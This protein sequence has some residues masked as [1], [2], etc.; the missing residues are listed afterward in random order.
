MTMSC[1]KNKRSPILRNRKYM[2]KLGKKGVRWL[3]VRAEWL[4]Q[5]PPNHQGYYE[6][7]ICGEWLTTK[8]VQLDH[9][10]SRTRHPE[11]IEEFSNLAP[12]CR[13][14]NSAK[15]SMSLEEYLAVDKS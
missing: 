3:K 1:F 11:L 2:Q 6:C 10:K 4:K 7:Y 8:E 13:R 12:I 5:N 9:I 14:D 15:G